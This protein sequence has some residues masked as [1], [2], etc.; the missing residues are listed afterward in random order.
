[1]AAGQD[2]IDKEGHYGRYFGEID[3]GVVEEE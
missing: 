2:P 3:V 1:V